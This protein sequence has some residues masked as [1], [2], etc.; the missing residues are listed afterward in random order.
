MR[1]HRNL[2]LARLQIE[3]QF[4]GQETFIESVKKAFTSQGDPGPLC[5]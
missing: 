2:V 4:Y 5:N 1:E 3:L